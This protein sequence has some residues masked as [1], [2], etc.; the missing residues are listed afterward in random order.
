MSDVSNAVS[1]ANDG[2]LS[3]RDAVGILDRPIEREQQEPATAEPGAPPPPESSQE[4]DTGPAPEPVPGE[5]QTEETDPADAPSIEP[6][7]SW[8]KDHKDAFKALP[9]HLQQMVAES[10]R[11]READFLRRTNEVAE[12]AKATEAER[13]AAE[14]AR[15]QYEQAL[16]T[17]YQQFATQFQAEFSDIKT[18][19]DVSN[20]RQNDPMRFMA[21]QEAREK[22]QALAR[23]A[24]VAQSRQ[25]E[26]R[27]KALKSYADEQDRL[28]VEKA[29]EFGDKDKVPQLISE[30]RSLLADVGFDEGE[31]NALYYGMKPMSFRDHRVQLL[32]RDAMRFRAAEKARAKAAVKPVPPVQ[33]PGVPISKSERASAEL[34]ALDDRL[35]KTGSL[36]D[37]VALL[38]ARSKRA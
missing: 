32:V 5:E 6:P 8:S 3:I 36:K 1:A 13:K 11:A 10:E 17:L 34:K 4:E 38:N 20:M 9:A 19:D 18:W 25:M 21:W 37:A 16:P 7:R 30:V 35:S 12:K 15:Q 22:G 24:Q 26:E 27:Q 31:L 14:Q 23:E 28:F 33:R 29:P 2:P